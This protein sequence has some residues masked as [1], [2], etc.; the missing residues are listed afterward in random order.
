[1]SQLQV[2]FL[3]SVSQIILNLI[4]LLDSWMWWNKRNLDLLEQEAEPCWL[5]S[6]GT[7]HVQ[8]PLVTTL[9]IYWSPMQGW[10]GAIQ[11]S[12]TLT[13]RLSSLSVDIWL[14]HGFV[15]V[16]LQTRLTDNS[17]V[18]SS[19]ECSASDIWIYLHCSSVLLQNLI[20]R[21][22]LDKLNVWVKHWG[23]TFVVFTQWVKTHSRLDYNFPQCNT[24]NSV[25]ISR[26]LQQ[27]L[28]WHHS[29]QLQ[30]CWW[31]MWSKQGPTAAHNTPVK[32]H[33][34]I[35]KCSDETQLNSLACC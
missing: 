8:P 30:L 16:W 15:S 13:P 5:S 11:G 3:C 7:E 2:V 24:L 34:Y 28:R 12:S 6:T 35:L 17:S 1:M 26:I 29:V 32:E 31:C 21:S 27:N 23:I 20:L 33:S 22:E 18:V 19:I 14:Q 25:V 10:R 4:P 9:G